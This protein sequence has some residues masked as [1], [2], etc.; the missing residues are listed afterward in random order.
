LKWSV[1]GCDRRIGKTHGVWD[2]I[3]RRKGLIPRQ[4]Q[5]ALHHSNEYQQRI[6]HAMSATAAWDYEIVM[7]FI[8]QKHTAPFVLHFPGGQ[9]CRLRT[10]QSNALSNLQLTA[11]DDSS[12]QILCLE[13]R[14]TT[15][16][17]SSTIDTMFTSWQSCLVEIS[18]SPLSPHQHDTFRPRRSAAAACRMRG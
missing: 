11:T 4:R 12:L 13:A 10:L 8:A 3:S 5:R 9:P 7:L 16:L 1:V 2:R 14:Q 17:T 6:I 15:Y 18:K